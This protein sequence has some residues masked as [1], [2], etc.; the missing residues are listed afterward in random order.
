MTEWRDA[1]F[2][3]LKA[4]QEAIEK[5]EHDFTCPICGAPARWE[6]SEYNGHVHSW[7]TRCEMKVIE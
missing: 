7:C 6:R 4:E 5:S 2:K 3:W 1:L